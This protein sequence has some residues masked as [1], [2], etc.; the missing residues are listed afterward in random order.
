MIKKK[1]LYCIIM[2]GGIGSRFWPLSRVDKPKQFIDILGTG[3]SLLQQTFDRMSRVCPHE[4][5]LIVTSSAYSSLVN[6]QIPNLLP[7]QV[8]LEPLR[9]NTA[10]CIA[11][12]T[13]KIKQKNPDAIAIVAPSDHLIL[14]EDIFLDTILKAAEFASNSNALITLGIRPSRPET[15]YGYIQVGKPVKE[16]TSLFRVKTFTEK[17]NLEL[18]QKFLESGEFFWNSGLFIW[19]IASISEALESHLPEVNSLFKELLPVYGTGKE[20]EA[21]ATAYSECRNISI[22]YGVMEKADNVYVFCSEFGWSDLGTWGSLYTHLPHDPHGN[23]AIAQQLMLYQTSNSIFNIPK[24]KLAVIQGLDDYIVVDT[25]DVLL[26]CKKQDEHQIRNFVNDV[27]M[28][29]KDFA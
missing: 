29:K 10:P 25:K 18:A 15:G 14:N 21:I 11:Y 9:R 7:G 12:A 3:K 8:L 4:N 22:D 2:A 27:L 17:P 20:T 6:E 16:I 5:I 1:N 26:I 13:Y 28:N 23:A 24:T 19:S